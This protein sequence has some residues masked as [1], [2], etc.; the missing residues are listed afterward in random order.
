MSK[1]CE[2]MSIRYDTVPALDRQNWYNN[3]ALC[4]HCMQECDKM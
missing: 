4:M 3:I 1:M 2:D